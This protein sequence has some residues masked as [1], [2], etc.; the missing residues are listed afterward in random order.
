MVARI[1]SFKCKGIYVFIYENIIQKSFD[2]KGNKV[3]RIIISFKNILK[4]ECKKFS[5]T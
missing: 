1:I 5:K 2:T 3:T 4:E